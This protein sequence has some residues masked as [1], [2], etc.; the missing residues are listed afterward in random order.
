MSTHISKFNITTAIV[1][2]KLIPV[3]NAYQPEGTTDWF[4][5][6]VVSGQ[7]EGKPLFEV[8]PENT[9]VLVGSIYNL[10]R[11]VVITSVN[12]SV[13]I[14]YFET[15]LEAETWEDDNL[16]LTDYIDFEDDI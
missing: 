2:K 6:V 3:P 9:L 5:T 10:K 8:H 14:K 4:V 15:E 7:P 12:N 11:R 13:Y 16:P 1:Y